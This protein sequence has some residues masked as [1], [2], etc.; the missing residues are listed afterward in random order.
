MDLLEVSPPDPALYAFLAEEGFGEDVFNRRQH[1]VCELLDRYAAQT[2]IGLVDGLG[3]APGLATPTTVAALAD[4]AGLVPGFRN[5]LS[6]L[7]EL[8]AGAGAVVRDSAG[9]F[10]LTDDRPVSALGAL[11][12]AIL[13]ADPSYAPSLALFDEAAAVYPRVAR[14]ETSG[15]HAL[16]RRAALWFAYFSNANGYYAINNRVASAAAAAR[17]PLGARVVEVGAGLGSATEAFLERLR[18]TG[19]LPR[20]VTYRAT[21]PVPLFRRRAERTLAAAWPEVPLAFAALDL[22]RPWS[23]QD[24]APGTADLVWGVNVFHLARDLDAVLREARG[25]LGPGGW[26]VVGEGLRPAPG[27]P[28]GVELPFRLLESFTDVGLDPARRPTPGF[29][30]AEQWLDAVGRAGFARPTLVPDAIGVRATYA[31]FFSA[32][33]CAQAG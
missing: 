7:L 18:A 17:L 26:L 5:T 22:N 30:T 13:D 2:A 8:L 12:N 3:L 33:I 11:R 31:G 10:R 19:D 25:A 16:F 28:V 6:W 14:G 20:L 4:V 15:E 9:R 29:L 23:E 1:R 21:E 27:V 24:V 32:A